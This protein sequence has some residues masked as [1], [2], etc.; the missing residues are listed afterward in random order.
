[1]ENHEKVNSQSKFTIRLLGESDVSAAALAQVLNNAVNLTDEILKL[2]PDASGELRITK[3]STGSFVVDLMTVVA[4][5]VTLISADPLSAA[6]NVVGMVMS[7]FGIVKHLKGEKPESIIENNKDCD[8][9][10][11]SGERLTVDKSISKSFFENAQFENC[12]IQIGEAVESER[13]EGFVL[14]SESTDKKIEYTLD[15]LK[16]IK[17]IVPE[18]IEEKENVFT[19]WSETELLIRKPDLSG[20]SQWGFVYNNNI[21]A[22]IED[23]GWLEMIH[24]EKPFFRQGMRLPVRLRIETPLDKNGSADQN[25]PAK[26]FIEKVTGEIIDPNLAEQLSALE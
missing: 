16:Q 1:M 19:S 14:E 13:R 20:E 8:I 12:V 4:S 2:E 11:N 21:N 10:N 6:N 17:P 3:L 24:N 18:I 15:D 23:N 25:K 5:G 9:I 7:I 22:T 26:Y